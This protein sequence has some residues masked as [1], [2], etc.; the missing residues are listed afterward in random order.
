VVK[1]RKIVFL[2]ILCTIAF[3]ACNKDSNEKTSDK[4]SKS[5]S[6]TMK[7]SNEVNEFES[8]VMTGKFESDKAPGMEN[9]DGFVWYFY[10]NNDFIVMKKDQFKK[11]KKA[12]TADVKYGKYKY[13]EESTFKI[14][15]NDK[16]DPSSLIFIVDKNGNIKI[17]SV[18]DSDEIA[19]NKVEDK[20]FNEKLSQTKLFEGIYQLYVDGKKELHGLYIEVNDDKTA[21][22]YEGYKKQFTGSY[23]LFDDI[24]LISG[25][26]S[27]I[28]NNFQK[29][30]KILKVPNTNNILKFEGK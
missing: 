24:V 11:E 8:K 27:F 22:V 1:I 23:Y 12:S 18:K 9:T 14:S 7:V 20:N 16:V 29:D 30:L 21:S 2:V 15:Y 26:E 19:L 10:P 6:D 17:Q 4:S 13:Y 25:E 28:Y 3:C 5:K